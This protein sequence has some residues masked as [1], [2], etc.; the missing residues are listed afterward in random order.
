M[1]EELAS[2]LHQLWREG[3]RRSDG[4]CRP[5]LKRTTDPEWIAARGG[6]DRVDI[7]NTRFRWLPKDFQRENIASAQVAMS[8][9]LSALR[10]GHDL[11]SADFVEDAS[12]VVHIAWLDRNRAWAEPEQLPPY[13]D[14]SEAE[15]EK[16]RVVVRAAVDLVVAQ[17]GR[18]R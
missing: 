14:L 7:A 5:R 16:D 4:S 3:R 8:L 17:L 18:A 12:D 13:R 10:A 11:I 1:N 2:R 15:K 9:V 6:I